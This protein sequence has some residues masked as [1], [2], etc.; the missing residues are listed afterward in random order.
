VWCT[1]P[2]VKKYKEQVGDEF[3]L[4]FVCQRMVEKRTGFKSNQIKSEI[5]MSKSFLS[6]R[7]DGHAELPK[8]KYAGWN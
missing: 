6:R 1:V 5:K 4:I 8:Q 7:K 2:F 3:N